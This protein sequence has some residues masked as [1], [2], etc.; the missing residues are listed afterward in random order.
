MTCNTRFAWFVLLLGLVPLAISAGTIHKWVD[1]DG[2]THFSDSPP[3]NGTESAEIIVLPDGFPDP[4][5]GQS[6]YYSIANQW[7]RLREERTEEEKLRLERAK[8]A[9]L[10]RAQ[11]P[12]PVIYADEPRYYG[13]PGG[14]PYY[15]GRRG[16]RGHRHPK[17]DGHERPVHLPARPGRPGAGHR[18]GRQ[19]L[20]LE[21][22]QARGSGNAFGWKRGGVPRPGIRTTA[23]SRL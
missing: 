6:D 5:D 3:E 19:R 8:V 18:P 21:T 10:A 14:V 1:A 15:G 22:R 7:R 20:P 16:N 23:Q 4:V 9:A 2:V 12:A 13:Y 11:E 17:Y